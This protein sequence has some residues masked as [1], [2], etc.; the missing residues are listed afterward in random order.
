MATARAA[1]AE[2]QPAHI[3]AAPTARPAE[4]NETGACER[5]IL[6]LALAWRMTAPRRRVS[7]PEGMSEAAKSHRHRPPGLPPFRV[8]AAQRPE[9][10]RGGRNRNWRI[11]FGDA[12]PLRCEASFRHRQAA[13][14]EPPIAPATPL[15]LTCR[16]GPQESREVLGHESWHAMPA[17]KL[18]QSGALEA[19]AC[20]GRYQ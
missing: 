10:D 12:I 4:P 9:F 11:R 16:F 18:I 8:R 15:V 19:S 2:A 7:T 17:P 5:S 14:I 3:W 13:A 20:R 1:G 6:Q